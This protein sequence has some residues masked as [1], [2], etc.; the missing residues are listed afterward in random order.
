MKRYVLFYLFFFTIA[1]LYSAPVTIEKAQDIA[2]DFFRKRSL[3]SD[4]S[5]S[6]K[7]LINPFVMDLIYTPR[8]SSAH[9]RTRA[10]DIDN[11]AEFYIFK[12]R[13]QNGFVIVAGDDEVPSIIGYSLDQPF[14]TDNI[15]EALQE[16]FNAYTQYI[17]AVRKGTITPRSMEVKS[18]GRAIEPLITTQWYSLEPFNY[19]NPSKYYPTS[20]IINMAQ[21]IYYYKYPERGTGIV[22]N[23]GQTIDLNESVY[24]W[25]NMLREYSLISYDASTGIGTPDCSEV[26]ATAVAK[27]ARDCGFAINASYK[28]SAK[29]T[30][31]GTN[32]AKALVQNFHY[33]PNMKTYARS[34]YS[35]Q[36]WTE[37]IANELAERR[38]VLY[39][40][41]NK[42]LAISSGF[43]CDGIDSDNLFHINWGMGSKG[44]NGYFDLNSLNTDSDNPGIIG[45]GSNRTFSQFAI[46][47]ITPIKAGESVESYYKIPML[48][49]DL[50]IKS[51]NNERNSA[52]VTFSIPEIMNITGYDATGTLGIGLYK[53]KKLLQV[54]AAKKIEMPNNYVISD[55]G[56]NY[57][58]NSGIE[59]ENGDYEIVLLWQSEGGQTWDFL[60]AGETAD[61]INMTLTSDKAEFSVSK[62]TGDNT[63]T[64]VSIEPATDMDIYVNDTTDFICTLKNN[65]NKP[66]AV[67]DLVLR[68]IPESQYRPGN[69]NI[70]MHPFA[71]IKDTVLIYDKTSV[72]IK[73]KHAFKK[74]GTYRIVLDPYFWEGKL[75]TKIIQE[76]PP[77]ISA[78][79]VP[80]YPVLKAL[81]KL[82]V[83]PRIHQYQESSIGGD[84]LASLITECGTLTGEENVAFYALKKGDTPEKEFMLGKAP[85]EW[86]S[87]EAY[88]DCNVQIPATDIEPG[89]YEV[90]LKYEENGIMTRLKP[91]S[92]NTGS[93]TV[94]PSAQAVLYLEAPVFTENNNTVEHLDSTEVILKLRSSLDFEGWIFVSSDDAKIGYVKDII[95]KSGIETGIPVKLYPHQ[96]N[97][98]R[99]EISYDPCPSKKFREIMIPE[100]YKNSLNFTVSDS[101]IAP[102]FVSGPKVDTWISSVNGKPV[103]DGVMV[104]GEG[105]RITIGI[106]SNK[107]IYYG[108][109]YGICSGPDWTLVRSENSR[110]AALDS[111]TTRECQLYFNIPKTAPAGKYKLSHIYYE[112]N[113][114][115]DVWEELI[116]DTPFYFD[117]LSKEMILNG[118]T[119]IT[120]ND[121]RVFTVPEGISVQNIK[122]GQELYVTNAV[123]AVIY[124]EK[125][126]SDNVLVPLSD[127]E[128]GMYFVTIR[129]DKYNRTF[130]I[131][132]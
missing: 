4:K 27:L 103:P 54:E 61:R 73:I 13:H 114:Q 44:N 132:R 40:A 6:L 56:L 3:L 72:K 74:S 43:I 65:F 33:S 96:R 25:E 1:C 117:V 26:E 129:S 52:E 38:P 111:E 41:A 105:G 104:Q 2:S 106:R 68:F 37:M 108:N 85:I 86:D 5:K 64:V 95:L 59:Y 100:A 109:I 99:L 11:D 87:N 63:I 93:I 79:P 107:Q 81:G 130:K 120:D 78:N 82:R 60:D 18:S 32:I 42:P 71:D 119:K 121:T 58:L 16:Y 76:N 55:F 80:A 36:T 62:E 97:A 128:K 30:S 131:L 21:I 9:T 126:A 45:E 110:V 124:N 113:G 83:F 8:Q 88:I 77:I 15:P 75:S 127:S 53:D 51:Q 49:S 7:S 115:T 112:K 102:V 66:L 91:S 92:L 19:L 22:S 116:M 34:C 12:P 20:G 67:Q 14:D 28:D 23:S 94:K 50:V 46:L 10:I 89:E 47:G 98:G 101:K 57:S 118:T 125:A 17:K 48:T 70:Q 39:M 123:G 90:Y 84:I 122:T 69:T 29:T 35:T 24:D 31:F